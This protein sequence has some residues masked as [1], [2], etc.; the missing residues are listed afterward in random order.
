MIDD[1]LPCDANR[2]LIYAKA[3]R[4]QLLVPLLEKAYAKLR[5]GY[6]SLNFGTQAEAFMTLTGFPCFSLDLRQTREKHKI[7]KKKAFEKLHVS[8]K[9]GYIMC[10]STDTDANLKSRYGLIDGH[11]YSILKIFLHK[12]GH[13]LVLLRNPHGILEIKKSKSTGS[14]L[15]NIFKGLATYNGKWSE[16]CPETRAIRKELDRE[17]YQ[18]NRSGLFWMSFDDFYEH[19]NYV[20]VCEI[21]SDWI[22]KCFTSKFPKGAKEKSTA[23]SFTVTNTKKAKGPKNEKENYNQINFGLFQKNHK[24]ITADLGLIVLKKDTQCSPP[25]F[26]IF[27]YSCL[28][29]SGHVHVEEWYPEGEYLVVPFSFKFKLPKY[30]NFDSSFNLVMHCTREIDCKKVELENRIVDSCVCKLVKD[31]KCE[32]PIYGSNDLKL[33]TLDSKY[34]F[35]YVITNTSAHRRYRVDFKYKNETTRENLYTSTYYFGNFSRYIE[36]NSIQIAFYCVIADAYLN[37]NVDMECKA[38]YCN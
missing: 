32:C 33:N 3:Y 4:N 7:T 6:A 27:R 30:K 18:V 5:G 12:E 19:F 31:W 14:I 11:G 34:L 35:L 36:P 23:F 10:A 22:K 15:V 26:R 1:R 24:E 37:A 20:S 17:N 8:S 38:F 2:K 13:R 25:R 9:F 28:S 16:N 29:V 21:D